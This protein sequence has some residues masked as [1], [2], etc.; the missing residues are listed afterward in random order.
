[1]S[2]TLIDYVSFSATPELL[3]RCKDMAKER[4]IAQMPLN[5]KTYPTF[6]YQRDE[7]LKIMHFAKNVA[8]VL[9]CVE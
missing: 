6:T 4:F 7:N 9:G 1:M 3:Q 2:R 8:S 5:P